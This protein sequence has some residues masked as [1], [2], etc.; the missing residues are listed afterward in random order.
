MINKNKVLAIIPARGGSKRLK[1]KNIYKLA[2]IPLIIWTINAALKSKFIDEIV[3]TTNSKKIINV[4]NKFSKKIK[5]L[6]RPNYLS[7]DT[8]STESVVMNLFNKFK[9]KNIIKNDIYVLLQPTSPLRNTAIIDKAIKNFALKKNINT[10]VGICKSNKDKYNV[11]LT[12]KGFIK[13]EGNLL[14]KIHKNFYAINGSVYIG[15]IKNFILSKNL[16]EDNCQ[17]FYMNK[18][19]SIDIDTIE[20]LNIAEKFITKI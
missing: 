2:N 16:F 9:K 4:V 15:F 13:R 3:V 5:I 14:K 7:T 8:A 19:S 18:I 10:L 11:S 20:D 1:N 6:V 17:P 12:K